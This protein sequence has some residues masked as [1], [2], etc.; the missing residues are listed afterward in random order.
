MRFTHASGFAS[1]GAIDRIYFHL[2]LFDIAG[3]RLGEGAVIAA[4]AAA[5]ILRGLRM[6]PYDAFALRID[7]NRRTIGCASAAGRT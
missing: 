3:L 4:F 5:E 7:H 2:S 6:V 1:L